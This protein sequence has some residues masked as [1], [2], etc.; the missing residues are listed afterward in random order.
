MPEAMI[1][2]GSASDREKVLP[3]AELLESLGISWQIAVCSAHRSP[4][5]AIE[6]VD[7]A[8]KENVKVF[9]C[10]AGMAAHLAGAIAARTIRP[11]IGIPLSGS[12][13][14]G[15]DALFS[16]VQMPAGYPVATVALDKAGALNAAWLAAEIIALG[17]PELANVIIRKRQAMLEDILRASESL[18]EEAGK[19]HKS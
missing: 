7:R 16:T 10:A 4:E 18:E 13:L 17:R 3:C 9:I 2:M 1:L 14:N 15:M 8:E 5:R 11:V 6:L 12:A 19:I